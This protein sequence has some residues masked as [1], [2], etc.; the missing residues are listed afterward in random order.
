MELKT[1]KKSHLKRNLLIGITSIA[2]LTAGIL[3]FTKA[4]YRTTQSIP[5]C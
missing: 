5:P 3:T 1:L 2:V 4:K